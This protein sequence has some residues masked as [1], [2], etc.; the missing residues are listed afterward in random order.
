M[1]VAGGACEAPV[2]Y[3]CPF[4]DSSS[5]LVALSFSGGAGNEGSVGSSLGSSGTSIFTLSRSIS[6]ALS[7]K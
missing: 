5:S 1:L 3:F 2:R 7:R 6:S 4:N